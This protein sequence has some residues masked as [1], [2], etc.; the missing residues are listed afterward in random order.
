MP[1]TY[2]R[3]HV[4]CDGSGSYVEKVHGAWRLDGEAALS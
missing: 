1:F 3:F 4:Q 2:R